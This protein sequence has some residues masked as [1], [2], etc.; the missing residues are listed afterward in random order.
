MSISNTMRGA[1]IAAGFG[2]ASA[3][4][5][6]AVVLPGWAQNAPQA[7]A[8]ALSI[9]HFTFTP[10]TLTV[11]AGTTVTWTNKDDIPHGI[12]SDNNAFKRSPA[13]D[14]DD[15]YSFT[16]TTPGTYQYFCYVHPFMKGTIVVQ[17]N[18]G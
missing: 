7:S 18:S 10:Q 17:A 4:M 13:L 2:V 9:D 15:S 5:L 3:T 11:K 14:T 6:A 12:A 16:F 1:L 8:D